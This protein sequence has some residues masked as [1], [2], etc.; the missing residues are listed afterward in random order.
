VSLREASDTFDGPVDLA[1]PGVV[2]EV[3]S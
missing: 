3:G 2:L 1:V